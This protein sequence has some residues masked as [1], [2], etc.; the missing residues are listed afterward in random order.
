MW[1][2]LYEN[3]TSFLQLLDEISSECVLITLLGKVK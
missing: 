2:S 1:K 3:K